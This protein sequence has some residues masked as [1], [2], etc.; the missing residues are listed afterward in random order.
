MALFTAI[1]VSHSVQGSISC[2]D[3]VKEGNRELRRLSHSINY[4]ANSVSAC[5]DR[6]KGRA[7]GSYL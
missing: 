7:A 4:D 1:E 2:S 3:L 5:C 6:V